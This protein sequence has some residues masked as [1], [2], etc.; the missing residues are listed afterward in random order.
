MG[1]SQA[2][3]VSPSLPVSRAPL[4]VPSE[5]SVSVC[6]KDLGVQGSVPTFGGPCSSLPTP[7]P[8]SSS[9]CLRLAVHLCAD[10]GTCAASEFVV[11][12][13]VFLS[14]LVPVHTH[15]RAARRT[16]GRC[17]LVANAKHLPRLFFSRVHLRL[18]SFSYQSLGPQF[19]A[20]KYHSSSPNDGE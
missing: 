19:V 5:E 2:R 4:G 20:L 10:A 11:L 8:A 18:L 12:I 3:L 15:I 17:F 14:S 7:Q 16:G 13:C 6:R 9:P 1:R